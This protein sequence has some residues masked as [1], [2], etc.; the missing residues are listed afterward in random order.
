MKTIMKF[1]LVPI[2]VCIAFV[3]G[4][5]VAPALA[6]YGANNAREFLPDMPQIAGM[7]LLSSETTASAHFAARHFVF[8]ESD[9]HNIPNSSDVAKQFESNLIAAGWTKIEDS[10]SPGSAI[11]AWRHKDKIGGGL[12]LVF[13]ILQLDSRTKHYFGTMEVLPFW[14]QPPSK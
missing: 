3:L 13:S 7:S 5:C 6:R 2:I 12:Y 8:R 10:A 9:S 1:A 14:R 4:I 11:S